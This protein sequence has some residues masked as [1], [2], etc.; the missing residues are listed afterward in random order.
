[1]LF[2]FGCILAARACRRMWWL[3]TVE[4]RFEV[5]SCEASNFVLL[6]M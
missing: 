3:S 2:P 5:I 1:M 6:S 4:D